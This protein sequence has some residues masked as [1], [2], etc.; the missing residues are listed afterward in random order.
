MQHNAPL[1]FTLSSTFISQ[2]E[3]QENTSPEEVV[4]TIASESD[5]TF[6][7]WVHSH[8]CIREIVKC[9]LCT[10]KLRGVEVGG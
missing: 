4:G 8:Q 10:G 1:W 3:L 2:S 9:N 7:K 6:L 5:S